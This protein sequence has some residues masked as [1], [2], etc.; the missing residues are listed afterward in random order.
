MREKK[1]EEEGFLESAQT[2]NIQLWKT[3]ACTSHMTEENGYREQWVVRSPI[4]LER[5]LGLCIGV[6]EGSVTHHSYQT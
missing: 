4:E 1:F 5:P 3:I 2:K 6:I